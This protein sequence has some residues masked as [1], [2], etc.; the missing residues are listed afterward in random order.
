MLPFPLHES[1]SCSF[2]ADSSGPKAVGYGKRLGDSKVT[3]HWERGHY[4][5]LGIGVH[6]DGMIG[7]MGTKWDK[8]SSRL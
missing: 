2:H 6:K 3:R 5:S 8:I 4:I 7:I 1:G